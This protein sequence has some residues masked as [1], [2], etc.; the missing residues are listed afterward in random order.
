MNDA[1]P[2]IEAAADHYFSIDGVLALTIYRVFQ[3]RVRQY[4]TEQK[5]M[6]GA[7]GC[8]LR[9][10]TAAAIFQIIKYR[11]VAVIRMPDGTR[12][13]QFGSPLTNE[14]KRVLSILNL[15]ESI[16]IG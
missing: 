15:D 1:F 9:K 4:I 10:P 6:H 8:I 2:Y 16:Y 14:E 13:R 5:P 3:R 12:V 11:K 7:G